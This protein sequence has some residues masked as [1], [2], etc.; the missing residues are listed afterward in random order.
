MS[1]TTLR[2]F[3]VLSIC[4]IAGIILTQA[5]WFRKSFEQSQQTFATSLNHALSEAAAGILA[6]NNRGKLQ[7]DPVQKLEHNYYAVMVNDQINTQVL[8]YYLKACFRKYNI[9]LS[10]EYSIYDCENRRIVYGGHVSGTDEKR[11]SVNRPAGGAGVDNYYFTVYFPYKTAG[12]IAQMG[13]ALYASIVLFVVLIFFAYSL[14]IVLRQKRLAEVQHDFINNMAHEFKTPVATISIAAETLKRPNIA[15]Q[16]DRIKAYANVIHEES[17][18]LRNQI[19]RVLANA[20]F[21]KQMKLNLERLNLEELIRNC[22]KR[23]SEI[24]HSK[25]VYIHDEL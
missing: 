7:Q 17:F 22:S 19:E 20:R 5:F 8:E 11:S 18:R 16:P 13:L 6:Y 1:R 23:I 21:E 14:F 15:E 9:D 4:S 10:Y 25:P 2:I 3:V 24:T 12:I